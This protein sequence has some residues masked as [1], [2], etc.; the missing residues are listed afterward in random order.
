[1]S[2]KS[3]LVQVDSS[4]RAISRL[5]LAISLA[6]AFDAH[7]TGFSVAA[8]PTLMAG[9]EGGAVED[10]YTSAS[11]YLKQCADQARATFEQLVERAGFESYEWRQYIGNPVEVTNLNARY[12]DLVIVG[13]AKPGFL[14]QGLSADFHEAVALGCGRP[15]LAVPIAGSFDNVGRN[16]LVA[17]N[18][19]QE[20]ARAV[21]DALPLLQRAERVT[22]LVVN[23]ENEPENQGEGPGYDIALY[24]ARHGVAVEVL[25]KAAADEK[26][27]H[28]LLSTAAELATDLI[29]MGVYGHSRWRELV[30]G[31]V[32][33]TLLSSMTVPLLVSH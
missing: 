23:P 28:V 24:L 26:V 16:V 11:S 9:L 17:W 2:Y 5:N 6:Q 13:Q 4:D 10:F 3:L 27:G 25:N 15:V 19:R 29:V 33:H 18:A 8:P 20:A 22:V 1:M 30:L 21:T 7:L 32:S 14:E 31:G 12:H